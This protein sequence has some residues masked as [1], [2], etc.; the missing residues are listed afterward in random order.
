MA[1]QVAQVQRLLKEVA[2]RVALAPDD[3]EVQQLRF[4][5]KRFAAQRQKLELSAASFAKLLGVSAL[6]VYKWESDKAQPRQRPVRS[7]RGHAR[8]GLAGDIGAPG[9]AGGCRE[10]F[11]VAV[12]QGARTGTVH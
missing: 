11:D 4:S 2:V 6:S 8:S 5:A 7:H 9:S 12:N 1:T 3:G 10:T